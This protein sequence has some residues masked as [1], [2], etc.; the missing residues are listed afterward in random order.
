V[1]NGSSGGMSARMDPRQDAKTRRREVGDGG[2]YKT[3]KAMKSM[4]GREDGVTQRREGRKG[5]GRGR[6]RILDCGLQIW[7]SGLV[8]ARLG[9]CGVAAE[10]K[11]QAE[12]P[13]LGE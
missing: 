13:E 2:G 3:M 6:L 12:R 5:W 9:L 7:D 1:E 8:S 10:G 11:T 4:E